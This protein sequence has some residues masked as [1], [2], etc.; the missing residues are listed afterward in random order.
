MLDQLGEHVARGVER[1]RRGLDAR[2]VLG[3]E[4]ARGVPGREG[5]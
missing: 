3:R 1:P 5:Q 4:V 2:D